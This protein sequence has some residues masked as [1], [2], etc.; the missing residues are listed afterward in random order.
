MALLGPMKT[1]ILLQEEAVDL[2]LSGAMPFQ[3][4]SFFCR[5][6]RSEIDHRPEFLVAA[7][8]GDLPRL[9]FL[10]D[11][12]PLCYIDETMSCYRQ[13]VAG[14]W[15]SRHNKN[16]DYRKNTIIKIEKMYRLY[17]A[18]T[19]GKYRKSIEKAIRFKQFELY[20]EDLDIK[21]MR[22]K[23][24]RECYKT[25]SFKKRLA[26]RAVCFFPFLKGVVRQL[27]DR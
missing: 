16:P 10:A 5:K 19:D 14:S 4:S 8:V 15:T 25:L 22:L 9:L 13:G 23:E 21:K 17:D 24:Y 20:A 1:G 6:D 3:T 27:R 12:G 18:Y 2:I 26:Y 11:Q 7:P